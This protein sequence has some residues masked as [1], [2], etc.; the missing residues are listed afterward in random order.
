MNNIT[1]FFHP[2]V[3]TVMRN[4]ATSSCL[5]PWTGGGCSPDS[6]EPNDNCNSTVA[7]GQGSYPGLTACDTDS[8]YYSIQVAAG[9]Q[10]T[11]T[12]AFTHSNG[13]ID[14]RLSDSTCITTL[15]T[16]NSVTNNEV[17]TWT[18]N[19]GAA[20]TVKLEVYLLGSGGNDYDLT[21][22]LVQT[23][24][25]VGAADDSLENSDTCATAYDMGNG[26]TT[27]LFVSKTDADFYSF[28][29]PSGGTLTLD[30]LFTHANG[31]V[32]MFLYDPANCGGGA[33]NNL[34]QGY[35]ATD[36][37][38]ISY[39]NTDSVNKTFIL[40]VNVYTNSSSNCNTYSLVV[41][42]ADGLC[43]VN[44]PWVPCSARPRWSTPWRAGVHLRPG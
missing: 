39:V 11:V 34:A 24:P 33:G 30:A 20:S 12:T 2:T 8:D 29:V 6:M 5:G 44:N 38:H 7:L 14:V 10:L 25:C 13:D 28:C 19:T 27:G 21:I 17:V 35:S 18:N 40:E 23:D 3:V 16:G 4:G 37:E 42:G 15:A 36:N 32:D 22:A 1:T 31:D 43:G 26:T 9:E 41:D